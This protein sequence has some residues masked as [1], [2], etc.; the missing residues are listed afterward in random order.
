MSVRNGIAKID[1]QQGAG[2]LRD[3]RGVSVA[4]LEQISDHRGVAGL[5]FPA[6]IERARYFCA[7]CEQGG[8]LA[9]PSYS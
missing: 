1:G 8:Q 6:R 4:P 3:N 2:T 9:A 5:P 7:L